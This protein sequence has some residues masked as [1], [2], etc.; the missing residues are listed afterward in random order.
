MRRMF[1]EKQIKRMIAESSAE[2]VESLVNQDVKVKTI[3][4]SEPNWQIN[5]IFDNI[6]IAEGLTY[7]KAYGRFEEINGVLYIVH[8]FKITNNTEASI[9]F[10]LSKNITLPED[11][12]K[13]IYDVTGK[14]VNEQSSNNI[15]SAYAMYGTGSELVSSRV[16][17]LRNTTTT[18]LMSYISASATPIA[19]G[20]SV[21]F[22]FREFLTLK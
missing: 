3:E 8:V 1:S 2:V 22:T 9:N 13:K 17:T 10:V 20:A 15:L 5:N 11:I 4:Q 16:F 18:N 19:A 14:N 12:A 6:S 7:E 21:Y